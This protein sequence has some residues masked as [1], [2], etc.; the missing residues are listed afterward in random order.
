MQKLRIMQFNKLILTLSIIAGTMLLI[1]QCSNTEQAKKIE[2]LKN[3]NL[4]LK[5]ERATTEENLHNLTDVINFVQANLDTI[6]LQEQIISTK[7]QNEFENLPHAK[8]R[9]AEDITS[10]YSK[11]IDN[12]RKLSQLQSKIGNNLTKNKNLQQLLQRLN[13]QM[14][15]KIIEIDNL[16][17]RLEDMQGTIINLEGLLD[18]LKS[19]SSQQRAIIAYQQE[20]INTVYYAYGTQKELRENNV[21]TKEGGVLGVGKTRKLKDDLN[22]QY[23]T[24]ANK[25]ELKTITLNAKKIRI[26]TP[27]P[28]DSYILHGEKP[29]ESI[30]ITNP[31]QFWANSQYLVIEIK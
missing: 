15:E 21:I 11:L 24:A 2:K 7:A 3:E 30:K 19:I 25:F 16:R 27:H 4:Q 31:V 6:K 10:I 26:V 17:S 1:T 14:D 29:I 8:E 12:R 20:E 9:I 23:F 28:E 5:R 22:Q 13:Q 18:T